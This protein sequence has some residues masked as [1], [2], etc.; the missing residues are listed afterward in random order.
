VTRL[1][2]D[3]TIPAGLFSLVQQLIRS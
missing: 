3:D 1:L 2:R